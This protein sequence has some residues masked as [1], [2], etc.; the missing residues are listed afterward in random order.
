[1]R[2][3][4]TALVYHSPCG[5]VPLDTLRLLAETASQSG[6]GRLHP[7][8]Q[9]ELALHDLPPARLRDLR[10][11]L[12][13]QELYPGDA[14][15]NIV[16][17]APVA[18]RGVGRG[19][20]TSGVFEDACRG[21]VK[22]PGLSVSLGDPTQ[23]YLPSGQGKL[24]F[25]AAAR[26]DFWQVALHVTDDVPLCFAPGVLRTEDIAWAVEQ[27]GPHMDTSEDSRETVLGEILGERL[28]AAASEAVTPS[29]VEP[30]A[31]CHEI[32]PPSG[33]WPAAFVAEACVL[34]QG[35]G[36][37][38]AALSCTGALMN[39]DLGDAE[40]RALDR[41]ALRHDFTADMRPWRTHGLIED[42]RAA[43]VFLSTLQATCPHPLGHTVG[44]MCPASPAP[45][46]RFVVRRVAEKRGIFGA[47]ARPRYAVSARDDEPLD[48][49][50]FHHQ[51]TVR[52]LEA[53]AALVGDLVKRRARAVDS[54]QPKA[55]VPELETAP[56]NAVTGWQCSA[57]ETIYDPAYGD[58]LGAVPAGVAF[59]D[60][61]ATWACPTCAAPAEAFGRV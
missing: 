46:V 61:P 55:N 4:I 29:P 52:G 16:T 33:G 1:M 36:H 54:L 13:G 18:G 43:T 30:V 20:L 5:L 7:G 17:T 60:L 31:N 41:L 49:A 28:V 2:R 23:P 57:C 11:Q 8:T 50:R 25:L 24:R 32:L 6:D 39:F 9:Q 10:A 34:L 44:L 58:P 45:D 19:W 47:L 14:P 35:A 42:T 12:R 48:R 3:S 27:V 53:A 56:K 22:R 37:S 21:I 38:R 51:A 26:E 40:K 15:P 59:K